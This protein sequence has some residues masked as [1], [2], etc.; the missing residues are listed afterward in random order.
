MLQAE[1]AALEEQV[2]ALQEQLEQSQLDYVH[3]KAQIATLTHLTGGEAPAAGRPAV[4]P[5]AAV[6]GPTER[7]P[8]A[9]QPQPP[10]PWQ[11]TTAVCSEVRA[12]SYHGLV[13]CLH[14]TSASANA[15]CQL[16][17]DPRAFCCRVA[18]RAQFV[19]CGFA[20]HV[21]PVKCD[22][23]WVPARPLVLVRGSPT[24]SVDPTGWV[25]SAGAGSGRDSGQR[26]RGHPRCREAAHRSGRLPLP[27]RCLLRRSVPRAIP[28]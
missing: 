27:Q 12:S 18:R 11:T 5:A 24:P 10:V 9:S 2:S 14:I 28:P 15:L 26:G 6:P 3:E 21:R 13:H 22:L 23:P 20:G 7:D 4:S 1:L 16:V 17:R 19:G 25:L 8:A